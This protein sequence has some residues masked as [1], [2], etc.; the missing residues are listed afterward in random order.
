MAHRDR[1][2][3][4]LAQ[5]RD[6]VYTVSEAVALIPGRDAD[7]RAWLEARGLIRRKS[8]LPAPVVRWSDVLLALDEEPAAEEPRAMSAL[9][10]TLPR[11]DLS[12]RKRG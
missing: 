2:A 3:D 9:A 12:R 5:G 6:A 11:K 1:K 8:G 4:R 7:V 10:A